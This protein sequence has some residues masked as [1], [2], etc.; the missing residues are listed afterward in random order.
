MDSV[1]LFLVFALVL[2]LISRKVSKS[3]RYSSGLYSAGS[4]LYSAGSGLLC[5]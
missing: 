5:R 1:Y 4:G 3:I 2:I